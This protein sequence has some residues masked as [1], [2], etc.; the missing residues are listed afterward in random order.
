MQKIFTHFID[1]VSGGDIHIV[2]TSVKEVKVAGVRQAFQDVFGRA[3]VTG[4]V[5]LSSGTQ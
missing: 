2:V 3:S 5:S 1:T 4:M